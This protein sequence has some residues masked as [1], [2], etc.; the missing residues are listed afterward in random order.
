MAVPRAF[1]EKGIAPLDE[2]VLVDLL[3]AIDFASDELGNPENT[4]K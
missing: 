2:P 1:Y 4:T 3:E